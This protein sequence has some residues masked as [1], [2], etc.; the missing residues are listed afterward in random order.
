MS[1][2]KSTREIYEYLI[3]GGKVVG[4]DGLEVSMPV[5]FVYPDQWSKYVK[6]KPK[7]KMWKW[8]YRTRSGNWIDTGAFYQHEREVKKLVD[9]GMP[10]Q[11]IESSM[12][13]VDAE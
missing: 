6:P 5:T 9:D 8:A 12:I 3:G 13:E 10:F 11:R 2:F 4:R 7:V 1:D